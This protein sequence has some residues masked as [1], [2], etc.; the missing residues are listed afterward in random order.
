MI[1]KRYCL[2]GFLLLS[3]SAIAESNPDDG[4]E[5]IK[6]TRT[7]VFS[8]IPSFRNIWVESI[9]W[10][11]V[12]IYKQKDLFDMGGVQYRDIHIGQ[13]YLKMSGYSIHNYRD[14]MQS[15]GFLSNRIRLMA[16]MPP[17]SSHDNRPIMLCKLESHVDEEYYEMSYSQYQTLRVAF[18][19]NYSMGHMCVSSQLAGAYWKLRLSDFYDE[20]GNRLQ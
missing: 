16:G 13:S 8:S 3:S 2:F 14:S 12:R 18:P 11:G 9:N 7:Q 15:E 20:F 4:F 6:L 5:N 19:S 10:S 17:I 1:M